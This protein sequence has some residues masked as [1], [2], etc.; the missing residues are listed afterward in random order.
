MK[1]NLKQIRKHRQFSEEF[2]KEIVTIFDDG[3]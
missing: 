2:K 1:G 3:N